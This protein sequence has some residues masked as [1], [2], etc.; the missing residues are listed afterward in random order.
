MTSEFLNF[1]FIENNHFQWSFQFQ[2]QQKPSSGDMFP[3]CAF[4]H[5]PVPGVVI[6]DEK[7]T[8]A[9]VS[10]HGLHFSFFGRLRT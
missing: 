7:S 4:P 5:L 10:R 2:K 3:H 8:D 6:G 1:L 9:D